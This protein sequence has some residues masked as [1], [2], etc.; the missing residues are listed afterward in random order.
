[1]DDNDSGSPPPLPMGRS[2]DIELPSHEIITID[3]DRLDPNPE[4][5]IELL[6]EA[7]TYVN[8]WTKMIWEYWKVGLLDGAET[9]ATKAIQRMYFLSLSCAICQ[10]DYS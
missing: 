3:L 4:D 5:V 2:V 7:E 8:K 6:N 10:L 9:I 1:M